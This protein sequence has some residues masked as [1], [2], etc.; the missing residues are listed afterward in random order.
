MLNIL[1]V[2]NIG[3]KI[4]PVQNLG[5][6]FVFGQVSLADQL[7][8]KVVLEL[9]ALLAILAKKVVIVKSNESRFMEAA[10]PLASRPSC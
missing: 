2:T 8:L 3:C 9:L 4:E 10:I 7:L 6:G 1:K 5:G